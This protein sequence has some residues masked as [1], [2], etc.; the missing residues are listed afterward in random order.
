MKRGISKIFD[1]NIGKETGAILSDI[2][3][4]EPEVL[5]YARDMKHRFEIVK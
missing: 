1:V 3:D 2:L 5:E 4:V